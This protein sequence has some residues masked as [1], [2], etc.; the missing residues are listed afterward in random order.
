MALIKSYGVTKVSM[1]YPLGTMH[2]FK[3]QIGSYLLGVL[4]PPVR[5]QLNMTVSFIFSC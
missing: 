2:V 4:Q 3:P 1:I 5:C